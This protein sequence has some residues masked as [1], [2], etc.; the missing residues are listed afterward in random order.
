MTLNDGN[1]SGTEG[2]EDEVDSDGNEISDSD[3]RSGLPWKKVIPA[4]EVTQIPMEMPKPA[5]KVYVCPAFKTA[6]CLWQ[7]SVKRSVYKLNEFTNLNWRNGENIK[8]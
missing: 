7:L 8:R 1:E 6:V 5:S 4:E 3:G 2:Q